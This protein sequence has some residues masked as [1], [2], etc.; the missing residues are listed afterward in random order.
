MAN[1]VERSKIEEGCIVISDNLMCVHWGGTT[2]Q[3]QNYLTLDDDTTQHE[4]LLIFNH[5][6]SKR[7]NTHMVTSKEQAYL[8]DSLKG[9]GM[10]KCHNQKRPYLYT[11][12][13]KE[14]ISICLLQKRRNTQNH[15][16]KR[17]GMSIR[18]PL[19]VSQPQKRKNTHTTTSKEKEYLYTLKR[20]KRMRLQP[21]KKR[22]TYTSAKETEY[23][24]NLK[25]KGIP[26]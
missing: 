17:K 15:N 11:S 21:P 23:M 18:Q 22:N 13:E 26:L 24:Y 25:I 16:P 14:G 3:V 8:C 6:T 12:L 2:H 20:Q 1:E 5:T 4:H 10:P 19:P 7:R 9:E